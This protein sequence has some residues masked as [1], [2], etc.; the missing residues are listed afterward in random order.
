M[1][2]TRDTGFLTDCV[3]TD[4]SNNVG[5]GGA[6]N[7]SYKF[8]VT[9]TSYISGALTGGSSITAGTYLATSAGNELRLYN[10]SGNSYSQLYNSAASGSSNIVLTTN[11]GIDYQVRSTNGASGNHTFKSYNTA[12]LTLDGGTNAATFSSSVSATKVI[13]SGGSDQSEL[14]NSVNNDFKLTNSGNF[15][16]VNNANTVAILTAK[17]NGSI[18]IGESPTNGKF[19]IQQT[20]TQAA[21]W[22]QTGGTTSSYTIADF[23]TGTNLSALQ[24]LG[25]GVSSFGGNVGIGT[26][27]IAPLSIPLSTSNSQ[28]TTGSIEIQS[29]ALNN[30][31]IGDNIYYNSA[32]RARSTGFVSQIYFDTDGA[33]RFYTYNG[34]VTANSIVTLSNRLAISREGY[35]W[36]NGAISGF[37]GSTA[38]LQVNGFMRIGQQII[39]HNSSNAAQAVS[40]SCNGADSFYI[41]GALSKNSGSFRIDHP[42]ESMTKT[43]QL[44]HSFVEAPQA[45]LY[46]RGKLKLV[47]GKGQANIDEVA[48]MTNGTF[49]VLCREVQCF[50][51]NETGWDLVKG[52][53]IGNIIYIESQNANSTDEISWLVIGERKDKHMMDTFWT[54]DNGRVIVE[55]LKPIKNEEE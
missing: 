25:N 3:F 48:T 20:A 31:W 9:G 52:K 5:V 42:L 27:P 7:A 11:T 34:T 23:R 1:G 53:V 18:G 44:V 14:T 54:D 10:G 55:P 47:N 35:V 17:N 49:E 36:I 8:A 24:I 43:H 15:R 26:S 16:I 38:L 30:S 32:F 33:I 4:S 29:Y 12:I 51:T 19:E 6:A 50:T 37:T 22:V 40:I 46:Y 2:K 21:L 45:D 41:N 28:I 13:L 39:L